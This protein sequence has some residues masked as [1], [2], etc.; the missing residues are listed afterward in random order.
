MDTLLQQYL[1]NLKSNVHEMAGLVE[2]AILIATKA[3]AKKDA[4]G[5]GR[6]FDLEEQINNFHKKIDRDCFKLLARQSPVASDLRLI[7]VSTKMSV[8]LERM[9]DLACTISYCLRDYF[10]G[11]PIP[12]MGTRV[13]EWQ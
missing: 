6:V 5:L 9:G 11:P 3:L 10:E 1:N 7:I 13:K 12:G 2:E 4:S 8:D